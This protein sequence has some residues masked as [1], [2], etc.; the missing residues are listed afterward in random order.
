LQPVPE[1]VV[2]ITPAC[3]RNFWYGSIN[4]VRP[5]REAGFHYRQ[6]L[7]RQGSINNNIRLM[8]SYKLCYFLSTIGINRID[9]KSCPDSLLNPATFFNGPAG[10]ADCFKFSSLLH[11]RK[12]RNSPNPAG[13]YD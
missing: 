5:G 13:T 2:R 9:G 10:Q 7:I 8:L 6:V 11:T 4:I 3:G 12:G 1:P